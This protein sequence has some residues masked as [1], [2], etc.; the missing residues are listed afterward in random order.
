[1]VENA[2]GVEGR[3][4]RRGQRRFFDEELFEMEQRGGKARR[5]GG[6]QMDWGDACMEEGK[7][8]ERQT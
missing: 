8:E 1:M 4:A 6:F 2:R 7:D 3:G 5:K